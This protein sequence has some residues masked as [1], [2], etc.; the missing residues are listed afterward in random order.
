MFQDKSYFEHQR[1]VRDCTFRYYSVGKILGH[2]ASMLWEMKE[3][4]QATPKHLTQPSQSS[5][6]PQV[7]PKHCGICSC[8]SHYTDECPQLQEDNVIASS[9]NY[10][11]GPPQNR[12][13]QQQSQGWRDNQQGRWNSNQQPQYRQPYNNKNPPQNSQNSRYQPPHSRQP[14][15]SNTSSQSSYEDAIRVCQQENKE[16]R[17]VA[18]RTEA[19]ISHLTDLMTKVTS[20]VLPSTSTPPPPNPSPLPS[21]RKRKEKRKNRVVDGTTCKDPDDEDWW[22]ELDQGS[23]EDSEVEEVTWILQS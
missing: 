18:K 13:Y 10:Y 15:P 17:E 19:Q 23:E 5:P 4:Q 11:D 16:L 8:N 12:Q 2:I 3:S 20:Q 1:C 7:S 9:H 22:D 21:Q 6:P 14:Y